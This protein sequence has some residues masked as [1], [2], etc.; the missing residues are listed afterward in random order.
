MIDCD[1]VHFYVCL[2]LFLTQKVSGSLPMFLGTVRLIVC[3]GFCILSS[4]ARLI[5]CALKVAIGYSKRRIST[6]SDNIHQW[7]IT[8]KENSITRLKL[9]GDQWN[10]MDHCNGINHENIV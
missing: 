7:G 3:R 10:G 2:I 8:L 1:A 4:F 6:F 9:Q 5:D